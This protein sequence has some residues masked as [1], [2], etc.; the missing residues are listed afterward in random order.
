M[1]IIS[2]IDFSIHL[3]MFNVLAPDLYYAIDYHHNV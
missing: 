2:M 1:K 3:L